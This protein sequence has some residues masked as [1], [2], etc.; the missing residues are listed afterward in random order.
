MVSGIGVDDMF[1]LLSGLTKAVS[2]RSPE[3]RIALM[4]RYSG[5]AITI[6]SLTNII[7][8]GCGA[9][10]TFKSVR[11]FCVY[12]GTQL[13]FPT[14]KFFSFI[15]LS[16]MPICLFLFFSHVSDFLHYPFFE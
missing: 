2:V 12:T 9:A 8:F 4:M 15:L 14:R 6:T 13:P 7:A 3:D 5:V 16:G 1:I 11:N 10:S